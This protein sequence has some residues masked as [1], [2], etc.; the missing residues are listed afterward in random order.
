MEV[1]TLSIHFND[2]TEN[3][4]KHQPEDFLICKNNIFIV[5]DG[6]YQNHKEPYPSPSYAAKAAEITA[7]SIFSFLE[8]NLAKKDILKKA[9]KFAN[10]KVREYNESQGITKQTLDYI[11]IQYAATLFSCG[12]IKDD[13]FH[14]AQIY[15]CGVMVE[16][17]LGNPEID[18]ITNAKPYKELITDLQNKGKFKLNSQEEHIY[19]RKKLVNNIDAKINENY[20]YLG[21]LTG[22]SKALQFVKYG[23]T[24]LFKNQTIYL[25]TDGFIP[26]IYDTQFRTI[27]RNLNKSEI[28]EYIKSKEVLGDKYKK[29][30]SLII[31]RNN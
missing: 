5:C 3:S 28:K 16:D 19:V 18:I 8:N 7:N 25:Y 22:Q 24:T 4:K 29:E 30:K 11:N 1:K 9:I 12:F 20:L 13:T 21:A 14:F 27:A 26:Y 17:Q 10:K 2:T 6:V 23:S 15:D 31:V